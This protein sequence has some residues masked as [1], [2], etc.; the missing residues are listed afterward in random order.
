M[1][2]LAIKGFSTAP[3]N[4][5]DKELFEVLKAF[6]RTLI[7]EKDVKEFQELILNRYKDLCKIHKRCKP[8]KLEFDD[9]GYNRQNNQIRLTNCHVDFVLYASLNEY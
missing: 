8:R 3:K 1:K 4:Q 2:Y 6:D 5:L 9:G 7:D